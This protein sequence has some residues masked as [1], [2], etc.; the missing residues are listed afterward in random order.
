M[1]VLSIRMPV[2]HLEKIVQTLWIHR[3]SD[4]KCDE[5]YKIYK[6]MIPVDE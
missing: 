3:K 6:M 4:P 2:E 1:N 5:L